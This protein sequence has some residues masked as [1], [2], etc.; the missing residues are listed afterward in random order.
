MNS[1]LVLVA[2]EAKVGVMGR[3][4]RQKEI[5]TLHARAL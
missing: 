1:P 3:A 5:L 2:R 4:A